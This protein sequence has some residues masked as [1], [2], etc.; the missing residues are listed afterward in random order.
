MSILPLNS[1]DLDA[2]LTAFLREDLGDD[3]VLG[4]ITS[5]A[6]IPK[7]VSLSAMLTA[8]EPMVLAG[9]DVAIAVFKLL[10]KNVQIDACYKDGQSL[11]A[12]D[13][14]LTL[15]GNAQSLLAAERTALNLVQHLSGIATLTRQYADAISHTKCKLLDTRKTTP[16][17]RLLEK[18]AT[19]TG[20]AENHRMGLYDAVMMK[21][22]HIAVAGDII[23]AVAKARA[24][25]HEFVE[26]EC[27]TL[28]QVEQALGSGATRLLL[29]NMPL[30]TLN[31]AV[32]IASGK[33]ELEASGGVTLETI[34]KIAETGVDYISVG[35]IT[36]SA[37]ALDIGLDFLQR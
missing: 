13:V 19:K 10:D 1:A 5:Q 6:V 22:N 7:D 14:I 35:R 21:D 25:G 15:C 2:M 29:D 12:G 33:V 34:A 28:E 30:N 31:M 9:L 23:N 20:G 4:D 8:R 27:D 18:Y 16:G 26:V 37:P 17:L 11:A 36:Q 24:K 32:A 3:M